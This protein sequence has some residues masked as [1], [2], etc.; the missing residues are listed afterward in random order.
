MGVVVST[1][2]FDAMRDFYLHTL[3]LTPRAD[4]FEHVDFEWGPMRLL[5]VT[6]SGVSGPA[7][8]PLRVMLNLDVDDIEA[9]YERLKARGVEFTRPPEREPWGGWLATFT[10]PDGNTLQLLQRPR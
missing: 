8:D 3:G 5:I 6:H 10:D 9:V 1:D 2:R 4:R 7:R